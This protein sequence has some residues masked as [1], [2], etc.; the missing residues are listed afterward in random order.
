MP[1]FVTD[2]APSCDGFAVVKSNGEVIGCHDVK[3]DA[4]DQMVAVSLAEDIEPGGELRAPA[5]PEDQIEG[6]DDNQPGSAAGAG[7]DI[8]LD[9]ATQTGLRNKVTAHN[10]S[11]SEAGKPAYTRTTFGQLSAVYRRGAGAFSTSHRPG[12]TR[13]QWAMARVNAFLYLLRNGRPENPAYITDN[14]LLPEDHPRSTRRTIRAIEVPIYIADAARRGLELRAQGLGGDG[15][16]EQTVREARLM[17]SG[18]ISDDKAIRAAAWGARHA[19][20]LEAGRNS[21]PDDLDWPGPGAVAHY[22]WGIDP[23]DPIPARAFFDRKAEIV[24]ME[25]SER[26]MPVVRAAGRV[27][28]RMHFASD[29][30][31]RAVGDKMTFRGYAAVFDSDSEPLPFI[32]RIAPGAFSRSLKSK[33]NIRMYVNHDDTALLASTR[34]GTLR[35]VEEKRGLLAEADLPPTTSGLDMSIL[36]ERRIVDSMSFGFSVPRGGD[37]WSPDG[38]RRTLTEV[39]LHEISVVTGQPAYAATSAS[40]RN[41]AQRT[42]VDE[43]VLAGAIAR[44]E[45]GDEL[46]AAQA[47]LIRGIVDLLGPKAEQAPVAE[48]PNLAVA[49][50]LLALMEM[51]AKAV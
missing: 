23:L 37:M 27:E 50:Q 44:L 19:I 48:A 1:Y 8:E 45:S 33:N 51:Q 17:A 4:V 47:D 3:Q 25:Q 39:R 38:T 28:T 10:D 30:E 40:V 9:E 6:S 31:V 12:M 49:Q 14:D 7:G 43:E 41:L 42:A 18:E 2:D 32:E 24:K 15:L 26:G 13:G 36:L 29:I 34:S 20:D 46:D 22:L 5:P 21:D 16:T 35:L 11:M